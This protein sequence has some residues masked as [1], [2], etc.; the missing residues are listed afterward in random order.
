M[1]TSTVTETR[2]IGFKLRGSQ[3]WVFLVPE[4]VVAVLGPPRGSEWTDQQWS[5]IRTTDGTRW[6]VNGNSESIAAV[7]WP[8]DIERTEDE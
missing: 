2:A 6:D 8:S 7:I 4:H 5:A 1:T 3:S